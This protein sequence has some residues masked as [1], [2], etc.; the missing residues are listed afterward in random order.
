[1]NPTPRDIRIDPLLTKLSVAYKN[2]EYIAEQIL[3]VLPTTKVTGM[4]YVYDKENLRTSQSLRGMGSPANEVGYGVSKSTPFVCLDH[5]LKE[6]VPNELKE[7]A[8]T[9][10]N[11]E[12]DATENVT[13][14]LLVEREQALAT[15][16]ASSSNLTNYTTLSG[17]S[18][19]SDYENSDPIGDIETGIESVRSKVLHAAN[20]LVLGQQAWNK[21]KHHPDLIE[22]IKYGGFGKMSTQALADL[23]DL[24]KVIIGSAG[25][26][27]AKEGQASSLSYIWGKHAWLIYVPKRPGI[28]EVSFGYYFQYKKSVDKWYDQDREGTFVRVHDFFTKEIITVDAA[29]LIKNAVA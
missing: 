28:K 25:Y 11:P 20:T 1:M 6:L 26:E 24:D 7:Q 27:S 9:P 18:Q 29:Y 16:M 12:V 3:P 4:Y 15:Y 13:E 19:W 10:M 8:E 5:A 23:L 14:K 2:A 21:L 17:T 22:R